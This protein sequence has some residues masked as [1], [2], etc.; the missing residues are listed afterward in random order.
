LKAKAAGETAGGLAIAGREGQDHYG[1]K[2]HD[3]AAAVDIDPGE[4]DQVQAQSRGPL[5]PV[6]AEAPIRM[7]R[8]VCAFRVAATWWSPDGSSCRLSP[9]VAPLPS[10]GLA[11]DA[12][13]SRSSCPRLGLK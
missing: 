2:D 6:F 4:A 9:P 13:P 12:T 11:E 3:R 1:H 5:E 8:L 7:E 10:D